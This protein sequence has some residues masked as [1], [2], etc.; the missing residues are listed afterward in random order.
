M[1]VDREALHMESSHVLVALDG[2]PLADRALAHAL[3]TFD[4]R[5]TVLNV[6]TP[7]DDMMSEGGILEANESRRETAHKRAER[8]IEHVR[9]ET[10]MEDCRPETAVETGDPADTI[11]A[12]ADAHDVDHIVMGSHGKDR[13]GSDIARRLLGTVATSVVSTAST[14]VTVVR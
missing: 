2:S 6:L 8:Q 7:L 4:C 3:A 11:L 5:L 9:T 12:Y 10:G 1:H 13:E 14:T